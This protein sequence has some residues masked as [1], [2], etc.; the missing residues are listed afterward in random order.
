MPEPP[1]R[2]EA[3]ELVRFRTGDH[4]AFERIVR[5]HRSLVRDLIR[6]YVRHEHDVD[7]VCQIAFTRAFERRQSFRGEAPIRTWLCR[8]AVNVAINLRRQERA[9]ELGDELLE[10]IASFTNALETAKLVAAELWRKAE[11]HLARL[12]PKQRLVVELRLFHDLPFKEI[13]VLADCSEASA[14][15]N[16]AAGV[17][18]LRSVLEER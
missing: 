14:R 6:R 9:L 15:V 11:K 1:A 17:G 8:I 12:P 16:F 7:D 4:E 3:D 2:D 10:G 13:G 5:E 18:T